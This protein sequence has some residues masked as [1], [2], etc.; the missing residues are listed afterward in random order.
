MADK[1]PSAAPSLREQVGAV[2]QKN[3]WQQT[4]LI[5]VVVLVIVLAVV[6]YGVPDVD[7]DPGEIVFVLV[8][9]VLVYLIFIRKRKQEVDADILIQMLRREWMSGNLGSSTWDQ[10]LFDFTSVQIEPISEELR[11]VS[12]T[13]PYGGTRTLMIKGDDARYLRVE[14][15]YVGD[16]AS[17]RKMLEKNDF[18]RSAVAKGHTLREIEALADKLGR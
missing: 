16:A 4:V 1:Q 18:V 10:L 6:S 9:L 8:A 14:G 13:N 3:A 11:L 5:V 2:Q 7:G 15:V 17:T 12:C